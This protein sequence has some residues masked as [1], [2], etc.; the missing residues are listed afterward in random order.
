MIRSRLLLTLGAAA[1]AIGLLGAA[2]GGD[3][4]GTKATAT[5]QTGGSPAASSTAGVTI[6]S[7]APEVDQDNLAFK[8]GKLTAKANEK[9]YFKN[10]ESAL[11][12]VT[13]NGKNE[14]G[15]MRKGDVFV[16]TAPATA[17]EYKVTCDYHPQMKATITVQ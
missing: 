14:S 15:N 10:S 7:G 6:P 13:I 4:S 1:V 16:W 12:T 2:C 17:G 8:P 5:V 9:V 3:D 11:H